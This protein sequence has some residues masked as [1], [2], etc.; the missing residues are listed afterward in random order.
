MESAF[1]SQPT[2]SSLRQATTAFPILWERRLSK[3][4]VGGDTDCLTLVLHQGRRAE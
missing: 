1:E 3:L 2:V 4:V